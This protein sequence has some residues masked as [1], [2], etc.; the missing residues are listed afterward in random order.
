MLEQGNF[1]ILPS[2]MVWNLIHLSNLEANVIFANKDH[3][4]EYFITF[5][6]SMSYDQTLDM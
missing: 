6:V 5:L 1:D 3:K 2:T 4:T